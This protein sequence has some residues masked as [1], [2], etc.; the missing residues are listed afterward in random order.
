MDR[1]GGECIPI[2]ADLSGLAGADALAT[3]LRRT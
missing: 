3:A 1:F 2:P